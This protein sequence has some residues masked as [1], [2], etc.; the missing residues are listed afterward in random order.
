MKT[1]RKYSYLP[2]INNS[3]QYNLLLLLSIM[4]LAYST[5]FLYTLLPFV[6]E[7][8]DTYVQFTNQ[9]WAKPLLTWVLPEPFRDLKVQ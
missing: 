6:S 5:I 1:T 9:I 7:Q 2:A 4:Y 3:P 8:Y